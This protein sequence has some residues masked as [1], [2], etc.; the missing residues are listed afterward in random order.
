M[1]VEERNF[2]QASIHAARMEIY[3]TLTE[4]EKWFLKEPS[5]R[6]S[7]DPKIFERGEYLS[8]ER[9]GLTNDLRKIYLDEQEL[10]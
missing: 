7:P 10:Y 1:A 2:D 9:I 3:E 6:T 5:W 4:I 8:M